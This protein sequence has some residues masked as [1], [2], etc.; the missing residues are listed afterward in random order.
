M[1][2]PGRAF[3]K[4]SGSGND[5]IFFDARTEAPGDLQDPEVVQRLCARGTGVGADGIVFLLEA[6]DA[7]FAMRY[8]NRD[9]SLGELCGNATLC[10]VRL[11]IHLGIITQNVAGQGF[12]FRTDS[13]LIRA[14]FSGDLP[15]IDLCPA[16]SI[17]ENLDGVELET[18]EKRIGY[19]RVGVPHVVVLCES[20][21][22][23]ELNRRGKTLRHL[24][25]FP[26]GANVNFISRDLATG[27]WRY[28]T[29]ER[30]VEG[31]TLACGTGAG[32]CGV[33]LE[34]WRELDGHSLSLRTSSGTLQRV[35]I[36]ADPRQAVRLAG[37][38][39]LVYFGKLGE[40]A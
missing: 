26:Q 17:M 28:R 32:S 22:N 19:V 40:V 18:G 36:P 14:N 25:R 34:R 1:N 6:T 31:E 9:G 7:P 23:I 27:E 38:A 20:V 16:D 29:F 39:T 30:G 2:L 3:Y 21:E 5:F 10:A 33:L 37:N 11:A 15:E 13:G 8:L 12:S 35:T 4:M 24:P